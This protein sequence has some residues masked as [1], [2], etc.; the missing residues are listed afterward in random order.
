MKKL[1]L[2]AVASVFALGLGFNAYAQTSTPG[3][4]MNRSQSS[5]GYT[6]RRE[7]P[8]ATGEKRDMNRYDARDKALEPM[9]NYTGEFRGSSLIGA[10]VENRQGDNLGKI[11]DLAV[12]PKTNHV[13]FAVLSHGGALGMG[14]KYIAVPMSSFWVR[15]DNGKLDK[16]VLDMTKEKLDQAPSF[17]KD[18]WPNR[19]EAEKTYQY[20]GQTPSWQGN[21]G[22]KSMEPHSSTK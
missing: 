10:K 11:S 4:D 22:S 12:D 18:H 15:M 2:T 14:E 7:N 8:S 21:T 6:D 16:L 5:Q 13:D 3:D 19:A 20:F 1:L 17:D 9:A